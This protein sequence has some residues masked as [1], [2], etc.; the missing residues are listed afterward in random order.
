VTLPV[1]VGFKFGG[2]GGNHV[3]IR[4]S[5]KGRSPNLPLREDSVKRRIDFRDVITRWYPCGRR[6][7]HD[8]QLRKQVERIERQLSIFE[9]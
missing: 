3:V 1:Q 2:G 8:A 6:L 4:A 9:M 5:L 7:V